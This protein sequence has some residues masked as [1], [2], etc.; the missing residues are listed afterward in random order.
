M[1]G[2]DDRSELSRIAT[3]LADTADLY[4]QAG[5]L[6]DDPELRACFGRRRDLRRSLGRDLSSLHEATKPVF[7]RSFLPT[8]AE[9]ALKLR[10][11]ISEGERAA[12]ATVDEADEELLRVIVDYLHHGEPGPEAAR[13]IG[14]VRDTLVADRGPLP[15]IPIATGRQ[16]G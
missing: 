11:M 8:A 15:P 1:L 16:P 2:L 4:R 9:I 3:K 5:E 7:G 13:A 12:L 6:V 14:R 10:S